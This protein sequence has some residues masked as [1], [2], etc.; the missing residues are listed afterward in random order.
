[1]PTSSVARRRA[2]AVP[3]QATPEQPAGPQETK[4]AKPVRI[5]GTVLRLSTDELVRLAPR[6]R[7][8]LTT[9]APTW[10]DVVDA[11]DWL[12]GELGVSKSAVGRGLPGDGP[13]GGGDRGGDRLGQAR[14][15]FPV[16]AG[17]VFPR[18]GGEGEGRGAEPGADDLGAAR[19]GPEGRGGALAPPGE[20]MAAPDFRPAGLCRGEGAPGGAA[21]GLADDAGGDQV[22]EQAEGRLRRD[23]EVLRQAARG[24]DRGAQHVIERPRKVRAGGAGEGGPGRLRPLQAGQFFTGGAGRGGDAGEEAGQPFGADPQGEAVM[25]LDRRRPEGEGE[26]PAEAGIPPDAG[27]EDQPVRGERIGVALPVHPVP[28]TVPGADQRRTPVALAGC[29]QPVLDRRV[30]ARHRPAQGGEGVPHGRGIGDRPPG[31]VLGEPSPE[32]GQ[33]ERTADHVVGRHHL[34][35]A[36][37]R[38]HRG[39]FGI[40]AAGQVRGGVRTGQAGIAQGQ[41]A[42]VKPGVGM[43]EPARRF[44]I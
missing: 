21:G 27:G 30:V 44:A 5:D 11:A 26:V 8:Y 41:I 33:T 13:G 37:L 25:E 40:E 39:Q 2:T 1:M 31:P 28:G 14:R 35:L 10:P 34:G 3:S 23:R 4:P 16:V 43:G 18:D 42:R 22:P 29:V 19:A 6:L 24:D 32:P 20:L 36:V 12:R 7:P 9:P 17:R 15:A 38:G